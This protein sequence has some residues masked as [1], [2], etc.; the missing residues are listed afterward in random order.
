MTFVF[1]LP[2]E[3]LLPA[4]FDLVEKIEAF[5]KKTS[6]AELRTPAQ[7]GETA[8]DAARRV[9]RAMAKRA[10]TE[11]PKETA[12]LTDSMWVLDEGETAPNSIITFTKCIQ[13]NDVMNFFIS[14]VTL[15]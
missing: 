6:I 7:D 5:I 10:C 13:R 3:K 15:A 11:Y 4:T 8:K 12:E 14:L 2:N 9:M 1:D